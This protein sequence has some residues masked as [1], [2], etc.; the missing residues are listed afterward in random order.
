M[1]ITTLNALPKY[2]QLKGIIKKNINEKKLAFGE[3][4]PSEPQLCRKYGI[5]RI[6]AGK[7]ISELVNEGVLFRDQG[8]GTFVA[9]RKRSGNLALIFTGDRVRLSHDPFYLSIFD[10]IEQEAYASGQNLF[11]Y[12]QCPARDIFFA[13]LRD[14]LLSGII[15]L[16]EWNQEIVPELI[17]RNVPMVGVHFYY[18]E[19]NID[20][21]TV[22]NHSGA[23]A[24][25]RHLLDLGHKRIAY[26]GPEKGV[27]YMPRISAFRKT[28][29]EA[30]ITNASE[31]YVECKSS[32]HYEAGLEAG[33]MIKEMAELPTAVFAATDA[34][35]AGLIYAL[36]GFGIN[37]PVNISIVG[38]NNTPSYFPV[39]N[40]IATIDFDKKEMGRIAV[41]RLLEKIKYPETIGQCKN[42]VMPT[43]LLP[44]QSCKQVIK[45][46]AGER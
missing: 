12:G 2:L 14:R 13:L 37:V 21:I 18:K 7:A 15:F 40:S 23:C 26:A 39:E 8:K 20:Y 35:A 44:G 22:D 24:A 36:Q 31:L 17:S 25:V 30:G 45:V 9:N 6:T 29:K 33:R 11:F 4:I 32:N 16:A 43:H 46:E 28:L 41:R 27:N 19:V 1:G 5:S 42:I 34:I 3:K 38:F 10:G